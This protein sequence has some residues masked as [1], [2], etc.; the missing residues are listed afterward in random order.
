MRTA[1][2][3]ESAS[4][5][6]YARS[7]LLYTPESTLVRNERSHRYSQQGVRFPGPNRGH[8][9]PQ[10]DR[11]NSLTA[12]H[13]FQTS[14]IPAEPP[15][16]ARTAFAHIAVSGPTPTRAPLIPGEREQE[17]MGFRFLS[18]HRVHWPHSSHQRQR[19]RR[20]FPG[21]TAPDP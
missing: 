5:F 18:G 4:A 19:G 20:A 6:G 3:L 14:S 12:R 16:V 1:P 2:H 11:R 13:F 10:A 21:S 8:S 9:A 7:R 15:K 17:R